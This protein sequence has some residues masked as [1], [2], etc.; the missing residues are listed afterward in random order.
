M[1]E[2]PGA[3]DRMEMVGERSRRQATQAFLLQERLFRPPP[4]P[5]SLRWRWGQQP[6]FPGNGQEQLVGQHVSL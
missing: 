2:T 5:L 1:S 6:G 3:A 4:T